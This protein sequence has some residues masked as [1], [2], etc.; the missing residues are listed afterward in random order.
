M[1]FRTIEFGSDDFRMECELRNEALRLPLGLNLYDEDIDQE[2]DQMHFGLFDQNNNILACVITVAYPPDE[3]KIRQMA[4]RPGYC[5]QGHGR[6]LLRFLEDYLA[7]RGITHLFMHARMTAAGF[8]E[9]LGYERI[10]HEFVEVGIPHIRM[11][12]YI[13]PAI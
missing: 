3:G 10:G 4:V 13:Q 8:Y 11:E 12:K 1:T 2:R 6:N 9:K 7:G 5:R